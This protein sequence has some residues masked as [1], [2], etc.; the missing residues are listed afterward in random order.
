MER[1]SDAELA[2]ALAAAL[3]ALPEAYRD[4]LTLRLVHGLEPVA[5]AHALGRPLETVKTQLKR[6]KERLRDALPRSLAALVTFE[7]DGMTAVRHAVLAAA[8]GTTA[9]TA[10]ATVGVVI[11]GKKAVGVAVV[12]ACVGTLWWSRST[13]GGGDDVAPVQISGGATLASPASEPDRATELVPAEAASREAVATPREPAP[14]A[15][16]RL[17]CRVSFESDGAPAEGVSVALWHTGLGRVPARPR[18]IADA[19]G[20]VVFEGLPPGRAVV[21]PAR[22]GVTSV[23]RNC[24]SSKPSTS[25]SASTCRCSK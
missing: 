8:Q 4:V 11:M 22:S 7:G 10:L 1:A 6:G 23:R 19:S 20:R 12:L 13:V 2:E 24:V 25:R 5:I 18:A 16:A 21:V 14:R 3:A 15:T 9:G 17:T